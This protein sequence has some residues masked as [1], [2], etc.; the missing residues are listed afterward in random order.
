MTDESAP[1]RLVSGQG[2]ADFKLK[3]ALRELQSRAPTDSDRD[4]LARRLSGLLREP[5]PA[6]STTNAG[7]KRAMVGGAA[8]F[9]WLKAGAAVAALLAAGVAAYVVTRPPPA[10]VSARAAPQGP[11]TAVSPPKAE[12]PAAPS[13]TATPAPIAAPAPSAKL[14]RAA[15]LRL[16]K[17][18]QTAL[19]A[20]PARALSLTAEHASRFPRSSLAQ[21]R[22]L[23]AVTALLRLG[24]TAEAR[25]R[26]EQFRQRFPSSPYAHRIAAALPATSSS[27]E[28]PR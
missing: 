1:P 23:L 12:L 28:R 11:S 24:R 25:Q 18:A 17:A 15:E 7:A 22:E 19:D 8:A 13:R 2:A 9:A 10:P 6:P 3:R 20:S 14:D 26:A 5:A 4:E 27:S 21:E 16:L